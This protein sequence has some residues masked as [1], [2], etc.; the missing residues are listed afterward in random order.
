MDEAL[1]TRIDETIRAFPAAK[2]RFAPKRLFALKKFQRN[3]E[4]HL[5]CTAEML[6]TLNE[7]KKALKKEID[8][9]E[10]CR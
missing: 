9:V 1:L 5:G 2:D 4:A 10:R 8:Y 6:S 7:M 3:V